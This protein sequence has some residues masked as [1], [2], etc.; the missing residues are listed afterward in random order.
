MRRRRIRRRRRR[1]RRRIRRQPHLQVSCTFP[2]PLPCYELVEDVCC[3]ECLQAMDG[4]RSSDGGDGRLASVL[5]SHTNRT[6]LAQHY[7]SSIFCVLNNRARRKP[8]NINILG[9]TV[10]GTNGTPS[11]G[12]TGPRPWDKLGPVPG[13]NRPFSVYFHSKIAILSR[14]SLGLVGVCPWDDCPARAVRKIFMCFLFIG[15]FSAPKQ[16]SPSRS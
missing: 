15:F 12:Q 2:L 4:V 5:C 3:L 9:G 1:R 6:N 11:L 8:I 16:L 10:S 14:L 13:T 7:T